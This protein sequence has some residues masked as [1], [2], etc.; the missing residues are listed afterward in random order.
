VCSFFR[1][2]LEF[3]CGWVGVVSVWQ[4]EA[5]PLCF[6]PP[7][8]YHPN[9]TTPKLQ[10]TTKQEHTTNVVIQQKSC[11]LLLMDVL[12]SE[13]CWAHKKWN[14]IA[15]DIKLISYSSTITT[16]HGP[17]YISFSLQHGYHSNPATPKLQHTT[18]QEHT[19][20]VV[21]QQKSRRLLV[22]D[23]LMSETCWAHKKWN[24]IASDI[25]LISYSSTITM[26]H[27]PI[28]IIIT[29]YLDFDFKYRRDRDIPERITVK[30]RQQNR[31]ENTIVPLFFVLPT[32]KRT[33]LYHKL[34]HFS[35]MFRHYCFILREPVINALPSYTS[36]SNAAV[37]NTIYS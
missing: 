4:A 17:I 9:P 12:M 26:M 29:T 37:G 13:T 31:S 14:K 23:V 20:N 8:R 28:Y 11:R 7:H 21:I 25:K 5:Q 1:C 2:V 27:G 30:P 19:T 16:M 22:M 3:R 35:Y 15:S 10:H 34:S 6:S 18:K 32:N 24:K 36:I 33:Q